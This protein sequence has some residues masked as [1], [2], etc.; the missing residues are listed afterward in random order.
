M[1]VPS[2]CFLCIVEKDSW[3]I[4]CIPCAAVR[5]LRARGWMEAGA[6]PASNVECLPVPRFSTLPITPL[7]K[8]ETLLLSQPPLLHLRPVHSIPALCCSNCISSSYH[9]LHILHF[10]TFRS[11]L[12]SSSH[13]FPRSVNHIPA[14][15]A[16]AAPLHP[17]RISHSSLILLHPFS[18]NL[19]FLIYIPSNCI[20]YPWYTSRSSYSHLLRES[21]TIYFT[22]DNSPSHA[23]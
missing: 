4:R 8:K 1:S 21:I 13:A 6:P 15:Q 20:K 14:I 5:A 9:T 22:L 19:T 16:S 11:T 17:A 3:C 2:T 7:K 10:V 12:L 23:I 18:S